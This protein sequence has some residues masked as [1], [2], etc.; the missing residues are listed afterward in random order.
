MPDVYLIDLIRGPVR[1]PDAAPPAAPELT[2]L[3]ERLASD[4]EGLG[5]VLDE[6]VLGT[7]SADGP[8]A[9]DVLFASALAP[10]VPTTTLNRTGSGGDLALQHGV[11]GVASGYREAV[12]VLAAGAAPPRTHGTDWAPAVRWRYSPVRPAT[13]AAF[14]VLRAGL[15][16][17]E[18][19]AEDERRA[20]CRERDPGVGPLPFPAALRGAEAPAAAGRWSALQTRPADVSVRS[21][22]LLAESSLLRRRGWHARCRIAAV[23]TVA[24]DPAAT[25]HRPAA[26]A[27]ACLQRVQLRADELHLIQVDAPCGALPLAVGRARGVDAERINV[28]GDALDT[29]RAAGAAA[30]IERGRLLAALERRDQRFGLLLTASLCGHATAFLVDREFY[31]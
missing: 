29:G 20:A 24:G 21:A 30:L 31:L 25:W 23:E 18:L 27:E 22:A 10:R 28:D 14:C 3:L 13:A 2:A 1:A 19:E 12:A 15:E 4:Q 16:A 6:V 8:R 17:R 26:A 7:P 11:F 5:E 9:Q